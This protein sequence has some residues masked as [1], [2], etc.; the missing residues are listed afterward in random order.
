MKNLTF[1]ILTCLLLINCNS[2]VEVETKPN[3]PIYTS[4]VEDRIER[5]LNNLQVAT[6]VDGNF[7][8]KTLEERMAFYHT[9][10]VSIAVVKNGKI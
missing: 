7:E 3:N 8:S 6:E 2:N 9:P 1:I 10:A 4:E 5:V